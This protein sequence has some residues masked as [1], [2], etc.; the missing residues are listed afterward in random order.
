MK[1][2]DLEKVNELV[3]K[4]KKAFSMIIANEL[5]K[6]WLK[7]YKWDVNDMN[8]TELSIMNDCEKQLRELG[9]EVDK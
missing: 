7:K 8:E 3:K 2:S 6:E 5:N 9:V 1:L 4:Y